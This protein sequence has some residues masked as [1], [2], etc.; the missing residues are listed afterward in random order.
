VRLDALARTIGA[1]PV[2]GSTPDAGEEQDVEVT[3]VDFDSRAV[4]AGSLFCCVRGEHVDGHDFAGTAVAGGAVALLVDHPVVLDPPPPHAVPQ[5]TVREVRPAMARAAAAVSGDPSRDLL[6][7]GVTGTNGKTTTTYVLRNILAEVDR[8]PEV[9][10]TLSGARTTPEAPDLQRWLAD[11]RDEGVD[12]V[13]MEVSSHALALHRVDATWFGAAVF[14]NLSRDHLD[15]HETMESY[16]EAK[17]R[18]F[19]PDFTDLAVVNLDDPYGRLLRDASTVP[20]IGYSL[21]DVEQLAVGAGGSTFRWR[22]HDVAL[23][24]GGRFNVS[25][26]L[27]AAEAALALG[28]D[29]SRIAAGLGRPLHVPGRFEAVDEGQE[30]RVVVDFA[31]TPDA[32]EQV[33]RAAREVA[34][35]H[36]VHVV[37]GCGGDR[38]RT[39]RPAMGEVAARGAHRVVLTADNSRHEATAEIIAAV[40]QGFRRVPTPLATELLIEPD[41]RAAIVAALADATPGDVVVLAGKGHETTQTIGDEVTPF[42]DREVARDALRD[43]GTGRPS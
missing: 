25:N 15:F 26:A 41:R 32:L 20:T 18:L 1:D 5:L 24:I 38:D 23:P 29:A 16:F 13:A 34:G 19:T 22:G 37:F 43:L 39:K 36:R 40:Q 33:L 8:R 10:G 31:H 11:R 12:A 7:V 28:F 4:A 42:D 9:L 35:E 21:D 6:V 2:A 3:R 14:T 17:A 27:A 30:F